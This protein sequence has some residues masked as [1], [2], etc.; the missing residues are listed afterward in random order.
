MDM[1]MKKDY[2]TTPTEIPSQIDTSK[3]AIHYE[4]ETYAE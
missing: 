1:D 2:R 4:L 3:D